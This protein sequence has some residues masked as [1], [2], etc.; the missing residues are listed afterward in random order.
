MKQFALTHEDKHSALWKK[1]LAHWESRI[2][3][4]HISIEGDRTEL[5]T[6]KVRGQLREI[7]LNLA[8]NK[9]P[10]KE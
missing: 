6:V 9:E 7:R 2:A 3:V 10:L 8:L 4:L 5:E 1:L